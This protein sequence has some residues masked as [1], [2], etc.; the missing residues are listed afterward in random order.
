MLFK[1]L[2]ERSSSRL[3]LRGTRVSSLLLKQFSPKL[4]TEATLGLLIKLI[5]GE[6]DAGEPR[7]AWVDEGT[8]E[9]DHTQVRSPSIPHFWHWLIGDHAILHLYTCVQAL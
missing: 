4:E 6:T 2:S 5:G 3:A 9:G 1:T 7:P 8:R